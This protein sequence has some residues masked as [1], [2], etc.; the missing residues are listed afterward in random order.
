MHSRKT[1]TRRGFTLVELMI[2]I[3]VMALMMALL[4]VT[5]MGYLETS[6]EKATAATI[7][8]IAGLLEDRMQAF[9]RL[10]FNEGE[11]LAHAGKLGVGVEVARVGYRKERFRQ[12][13]PQTFAEAAVLLKRAGRNAPSAQDINPRLESAQV[14]HFL[15][16][17]SVIGYSPETG[18]AFTDG[19]IRT[20]D[21]P[22]L[23]D[24]PYFV[25]AWEQPIRFYRWP[26]RLVRPQGLVDSAGNTLP[27][28]RQYAAVLNQSLPPTDQDLNR[29]PDDPTGLTEFL[30]GGSAVQFEK[31]YHTRDTYHAVLIVSAGPDQTLGLYEPSE[32]TINTTNPTQSIFGNLA[33]P[34]T[35]EAEALSDNI[36][37]LNRQAGG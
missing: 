13:F 20:P 27:V 30:S 35:A 15:L 1:T 9:N 29:D 36:T 6:K 32:I 5:V 24:W 10:K 22:A 33:Q 7:E 34:K 28:Q 4:V 23:A 21:A 12:E 25:D 17:Q 26:T 16:T 14:L 18:E 37:N 31:D 19:Q 8:K 3:G 2:V 11:I